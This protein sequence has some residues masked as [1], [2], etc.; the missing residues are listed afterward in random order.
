MKDSLI[1]ALWASSPAPSPATVG[2]RTF[3]K[4]GA[5]GLGVLAGAA[6]APAC[7]LF[8]HWRYPTVQEGPPLVQ[9]PPPEV[10]L[11]RLTFEVSSG[12]NPHY[13]LRLLQDYIAQTLSPWSHDA[14]HAAQQIE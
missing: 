5:A 1:N 3:V 2:R 4:F 6:S 8:R 9:L 12:V 11:A 10:P 7:F 13:M 14:R